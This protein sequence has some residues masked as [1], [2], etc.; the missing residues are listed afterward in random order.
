MHVVT[1]RKLFKS[2]NPANGMETNTTNVRS[3]DLSQLRRDVELIKN[4][5]LSEGELT[6][7][8]KRELAEARQVPESECISHED[9]KQ[10]ILQK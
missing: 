2:R 6:E 8:A 1:H 10:I 7:W 9:S 4:I 5:L 3:E